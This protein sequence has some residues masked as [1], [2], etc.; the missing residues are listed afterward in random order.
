MRNSR[1]NNA[2]LFF[3]I[4]IALSGCGDWYVTNE[5]RSPVW[6]DSGTIYCVEYEYKERYPILWPFSPWD[7]EYSRYLSSMD[8]EGNNYSRIILLSDEDTDEDRISVSSN[9]F[10]YE[11]SGE[12]WTIMIDG[13]NN[14]K[15]VSGSFPRI[16]P[17]GTKVVYQSSSDEVWIINIDGT[18]AKKLW[19]NSKNFSCAWST[20]TTRVAVGTDDGIRIVNINDL[21]STLLPVEY[22]E[23]IDWS[24]D[25]AEFVYWNPGL[26]IMDI[27]G[28]SVKI[29]GQVFRNPKWSPD[30]QKIVGEQNGIAIINRDGT[31][32]K[33]IK[34]DVL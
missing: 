13:S 32:F 19:D 8:I 11:R 34:G 20:D 33:T 18:E 25:G 26:M 9:V 17:N 23:Y 21:E 12:V 14:K 24:S 31:N 2:I 6:K 16:S 27:N 4:C 30:N 15:I 5:Y 29:F 10:V 1:L 7:Q 22:M 28:N 3:L